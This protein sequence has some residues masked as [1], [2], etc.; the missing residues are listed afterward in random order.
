M[1]PVIPYPSVKRKPRSGLPTLFDR[2][3]YRQRN[4]IERMSGWL[5]E[6]RRIAGSVGKAYCTRRL[7]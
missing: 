4:V 3:K 1:R 7:W 6:N 2:R 5:K